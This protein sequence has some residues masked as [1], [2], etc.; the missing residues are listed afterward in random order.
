[1]YVVH[2]LYIYCI[3]VVD[4]LYICCISALVVLNMSHT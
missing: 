4:M 3:Y 2:M 1:M